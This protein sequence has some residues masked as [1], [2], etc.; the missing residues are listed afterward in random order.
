MPEL[1]AELTRLVENAKAMK[2]E[3]DQAYK[4]R[5]KE[6][7]K[8]RWDYFIGNQFEGVNVEDWKMQIPINYCRKTVLQNH[9]LLTD[10]PAQVAIY[11]RE[12][13]DVEKA[14]RVQMLLDQK[15]EENYMENRRSLAWLYA[16]IFGIAWMMPCVDMDRRWRVYGHEI[17]G[18]VNVHVFDPSNVRIDPAA[19][20]SANPI[21]AIGSAE[22]AY[23]QTLN[24]ILLFIL[25][26]WLM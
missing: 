14:K 19:A 5:L 24:Q 22:F 20:W 12:E 6:P 18:D 25:F 7:F 11:G 1:S 15:N 26:L 8:R 4:D 17:K 13:M 9:S 2:R 23:T 16:L 21:D 10:A 3:A